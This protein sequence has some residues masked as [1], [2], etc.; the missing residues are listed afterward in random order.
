MNHHETMILAEQHRADLLADATV[1]RRR[2]RSR[3]AW[4]R[5]RR[6]RRDPVD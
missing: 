6:A 4:L 1:A 2:P 5:R 3:H